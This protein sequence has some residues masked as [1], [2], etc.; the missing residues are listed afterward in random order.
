MDPL[1]LA[2]A[3][4]MAETGVAD[5]ETAFFAKSR[6]RSAHAIDWPPVDLDGGCDMCR[7]KGGAGSSV[8][9]HRT[10]SDTRSGLP[11]ERHGLA[12]LGTFHRT[13]NPFG[14]LQDLTY[15][16]C[17]ALLRMRVTRDDPVPCTHDDA[18]FKRERTALDTA[19]CGYFVVDETERGAP[20]FWTFPRGCLHR[21]LDRADRNVAESVIVGNHSAFGPATREG[22]ERAF[23]WLRSGRR[24]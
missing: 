6:F 23:L 24:S 7:L 11:G 22:D 19:S 10:D 15:C 16:S 12:F 20:H 5:G 13:E 18:K 8:E 9:I 4:S 21:L 17:R 14:A 3:A 1:V 2:D